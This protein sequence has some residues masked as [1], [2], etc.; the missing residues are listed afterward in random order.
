MKEFLNKNYDDYLSDVSMISESTNFGI[1]N[2]Q[3]VEKFGNRYG[4]EI[5]EFFNEGEYQRSEEGKI[6][7]IKDF[8][9]R[10]FIDITFDD[11]VN[12]LDILETIDWKQYDALSEELVDKV[13]DM[14]ESMQEFVQDYRRDEN[15]MPNIKKVIFKWIEELEEM[16]EIVE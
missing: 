9:R 16:L 6:R 5:V 1:D 12:W 7:A 11:D 3:D 15:Y 13:E 14:V 10:K 4:E 8:M 2:E